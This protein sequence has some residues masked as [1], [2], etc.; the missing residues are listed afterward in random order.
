MGAIRPG[1]E[2]ADRTTV[3]GFTGDAATCSVSEFGCDPLDCIDVFKSI[4]C[5][6]LNDGLR[7]GM[8]LGLGGVFT[9]CLSENSYVLPPTS[10]TLL[11]LNIEVFE[12]ENTLP[13]PLARC[14]KQS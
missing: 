8:A 11:I 9:F 4:L 13:F 14:I 1:D 6:E 3:A 7:T 12:K 10:I 5:D 2:T